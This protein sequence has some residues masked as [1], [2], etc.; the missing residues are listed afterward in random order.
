MKTISARIPTDDSELFELI[1]EE[2]QVTQ[3]EAIR[4]IIQDFVAKT[5][6]S[7]PV[8]KHSPLSFGELKKVHSQKGSS[9]FYENFKVLNRKNLTGQGLK[10]SNLY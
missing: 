8:H 1:C 10:I 7:N 5:F 6:E 9:Q 3:S 2:Y 4:S